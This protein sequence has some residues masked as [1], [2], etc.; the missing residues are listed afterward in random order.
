[1]ICEKL[2]KCLEEQIH[3]EL[4]SECVNKENECIEVSDCRSNVKCEERGKKY[5]L[6]NTQK[7][8]VV[9]YKIDGGVVVQD[10]TVPQG[11][12][13]CDY[14]FTINGKKKEA[15]ITELK[16]V[17]VAHSLKQIDGT[18]TLFKDFFSKFSHVY[19]RIIVSSSAPDIK[20]NP[21]YVNLYK[22]LQNKYKGNLKVEKI[23]FSEKD[24][25][26]TKI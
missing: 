15:I 11:I 13:K 19:G 21:N 23:K 20:A 2:E 24:V 14:L 25:E 26:L 4:V 6:E 9:L 16:G 3:K 12:C 22:K 5:V 10:K 7:N 1:M 8:H 18:L 17:D